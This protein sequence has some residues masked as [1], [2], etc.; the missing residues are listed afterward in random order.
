MGLISSEAKKTK[1]FPKSEPHLIVQRSFA[2]NIQTVFSRSEVHNHK[3]W[4]IN[5]HV[6]Y[7]GWG[8]FMRG[9]EFWDS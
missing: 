9:D 5:V 7:R 4:A 6:L 2:N 8:I 3:Q 1:K